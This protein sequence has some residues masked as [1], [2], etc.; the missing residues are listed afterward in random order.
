[1][2]SNNSRNTTTAVVAELF[3]QLFNAKR[4]TRA[5]SNNVRLYET[6]QQ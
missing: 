5:A 1:M 4:F 6:S 3:V 2:E